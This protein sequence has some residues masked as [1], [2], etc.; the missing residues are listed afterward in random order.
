MRILNYG[1]GAVGLGI[2]SCLIAA[3]CHLDIL[4]RPQTVN[5]LTQSG[6]KRDGLLGTIHCPPER[7]RAYASLDLLPPEP[8]DFILVSTKSFDSAEAA[9][10]LY[11]HPKLFHPS[12]AIVLFQNGWG[13]AEQFTPYFEAS[14]IFNARVITG[15]VRPQPD[16]VTITVHADAIHIGCLS[17][18]KT[19]PVAPLCQKIS[20]GGIPAQTTNSI[21]K[22]LWAKMLYNC[23]LNSLGAVLDAAYGEL[24]RCSASRE[25]C[26]AII[27]EVFR[28]MTA[29]GYETH[30]RT[31]EEYLG[32]F[33]SSLLP[34]TASHHSS[35][36]QDIKAGK[37]TE[38]DA[39]TGVVIQ[40]AR[41][42]SIPVPTNDVVYRM[43]KFLEQK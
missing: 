41:R 42:H 40:L 20:Q 6:F 16:V 17:G 2:D 36:L 13:N 23:A 9:R 11:R 38:I 24:G 43:I 4:A 26:D 7:F 22:D 18:K 12:T 29:A 15:F 39:L 8:Y 35:T 1:A 28:V 30:W 27:T 14:H 21:A 3:G 10:D 25:L 37:K 19:I 5:A 32:V 34:L 31:S 33:Y